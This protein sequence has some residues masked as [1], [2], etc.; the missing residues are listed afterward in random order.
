M[1]QY[2][3]LLVKAHEAQE[4]AYVP[5]SKFKVGAAVLMKSGKIYTGCNIE[6]ASFGATNCAE[7]T[8]IF[9]AVSEGE[10]E[11]AAIAI[12]GSHNEFT[13]P[14]GICRQVI[15][16]FMSEGDFIFENAFFMFSSLLFSLIRIYLAFFVT[17]VLLPV[18]FE[19]F[20]FKFFLELLK[21]LFFIVHFLFSFVIP[22]F[23]NK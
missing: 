15:A 18:A 6:N 5:Y 23:L 4:Q 21:L 8:A 19:L 22:Y 10:H 11:I 7:R 12:V 9:K 1:K 3:E 16:E 20:F 2:K 17:T 13:Y 14:C